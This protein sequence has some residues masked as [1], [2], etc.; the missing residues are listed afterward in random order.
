MMKE[1]ILP[2]LIMILITI[3]ATWSTN[4]V[5]LDIGA[6]GQ[7]EK[8]T[9]DGGLDLVD[10]NLGTAKTLT[11][12]GSV[13][14][15]DHQ[16]VPESSLIA[17]VG[18]LFIK[19]SG[20][21][22]HDYFNESG[23]GNSGAATLW[24]AG[25]DR[26]AEYLK[27]AEGGINSFS[28]KVTPLS[29]DLT[30]IKD[31]GA[32]YAKNKVQPSNP[33]GGGGG[34][35]PLKL[36]GNPGFETLANAKR[37]IGK[38]QATLVIPAGTYNITSDPDYPSNIE[39]LMMKGAIF[40]ISSGVTMTI[41]GPFRAGNNRHFTFGSSTAKVRFGDDTELNAVWFIN[42]GD[43]SEDYPWTGAEGGG[44]IGEAIAHNYY[45][46]S[47]RGAYIYLPPGR[48]SVTETINCNR[49]GIY[50]R[51]AGL[52]AY[53]GGTKIQFSPTSAKVLF[54]YE[55]TVESDLLYYG[56]VSGVTLFSN[57]YANTMI[58]LF[59]VSQMKFSDIRQFEW[60]NGIGIHICGREMTSFERIFL[61]AKRPIV[62]SK[63]TRAPYLDCDAFTFKDMQI[64]CRDNGTYS[65]CVYVD[66]GCNI[67]HL[68]FSGWQDWLIW[69]YGFYFVTT[70][71]I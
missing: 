42:G 39:L 30:L 2:L 52:H 60:T 27:R 50:I 18:S 21:A 71:S 15:G 44:G 32:G 59:D 35:T 53:S 31:K 67:D 69:H 9:Y 11:I 20:S 3:A 43:G 45:A 57:S 63:N 1:L 16:T 17:P 70:T 22:P 4:N 12:K 62:I 48:F 55:N 26:D 24:A 61:D 34:S 19:T 8:L 46:D 6:R 28:E 13:E 54:N 25:Q 65:A 14:A 64:L 56:G 66:D 10:A 36:L 49:S 37:T 7:T 33:P 41:L 58:K 23:T 40:N 29:A 38:N 5:K 47:Y 51:G 68:N